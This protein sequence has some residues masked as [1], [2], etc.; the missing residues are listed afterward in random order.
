MGA[1]SLAPDPQVVQSGFT[2]IGA[3]AFQYSIAQRSSSHQCPVLD[4]ASTGKN[5]RSRLHCR[6]AHRFGSRSRQRFSKKGNDHEEKIINNPDQFVDKRMVVFS[7]PTDQ[8]KTPATTAAFSIARRPGTGRVGIVT[9]SSGH[10]PLQRL[11]RTRP[12]LRRRHRQHLLLPHRSSSARTQQRRS[13]AARASSS[14]TEHG[15]DV[16]SFDLAVDLLE[17]DGIETRTV[18]GC[19]DVASQPKERARDR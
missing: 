7:W 5:I 19:D 17:L 8:V 6:Q 2:S 10:L 15:G 3:V 1:Y 11:R 4:F 9:G 18:L 13:M 16:F 12:V 14:S